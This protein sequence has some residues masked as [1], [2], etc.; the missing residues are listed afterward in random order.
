MPSYGVRL[1]RSSPLQLPRHPT[2]PSVGNFE[3][4]AA[5]EASAGRPLAIDLFSG[6]G[7]LS[8][9]IE[10]AGWTVALAVD[11]DARA[12]ETHRSNFPGLALDLDLS[13][14]ENRD[15]V[16]DLLAPL[17]I[18][19]VAGGP[20]CQPFSRAGRSKIRSLVNAGLRDEY[21]NRREL[22][23]AF[24]DI[25][26]RVRPRAIVMENVP[27]MGLGDDFRVVRY[28]VE[29]IERAGYETSLQIVD[30]WKFGVPQHRKRLILL[31]RRDGYDFRWPE[32]VSAVTTL[33][34]AIGDLPRLGGVTGGREMAYL[35]EGRQSE[36][37]AKMR[38][39]SQNDVIYDHMTRPVRDDDLQ[40]FQMM[41]SSTLYSQIPESLRRYKAD[42]FDDKYKR[43]DWEDVSRSITA[44]IAKDGYW[45][46]HP[47]EHRTLTVREAAR[48]Q[49][50]PDGFR[51]SGT[52]SDAFKQIGNAVPPLLGEAAAVAVSDR[53]NDL[54]SGEE[55][56]VSWSD[57][58]GALMSWAKIQREHDYWFMFPGPGMTPVAALVAVV[59]SSNRCSLSTRR[60]VLELFRG[61]GYLDA[62]SLAAGLEILENKTAKKGLERLAHL[63]DAVLPWASPESIPELVSL[64]PSEIRLYELLC[65]SD[66]FLQSQP[67]WRVASRLTQGDT[68]LVNRL[69]DGRINLSR[70]VGGDD[71][72]P[73][74]MAA[75]RL[76]AETVCGARRK[77][78]TKCPLVNW[79]S[80]RQIESEN[81]FTEGQLALSI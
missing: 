7:G 73:T 31:A 52:R 72:A 38:A 74:R 69:T 68:R 5:C 43:L 24:L 60:S 29:E 51:F 27:D 53:V 3:H 21:D 11:H 34:D 26:L 19:L 23:S 35:Q 75:V 76:V 36:F 56:V 1:E 30:A 64:R 77:V 78:C 55:S 59:L 81:P 20:P 6:A 67:V 71:D 62:E 17:S 37:A 39:S 80:G 44:H 15:V 13:M 4:W 8:A 28:M 18:D 10:A 22:W 12:L 79:C 42:S 48:I 41:D 40:I 2:G 58:R 65:G 54:R 9:G 57:A 70:I 32:E 46:I 45:Y 49:T 25:A 14:S 63:S 16:V 33:R 47:E 61:R 50:F 66:V